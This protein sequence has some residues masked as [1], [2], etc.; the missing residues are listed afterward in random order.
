MDTTQQ[1]RLTK[2]EWDSVEVP[3]SDA[4][5]RIL[6]LIIEGYSNVDIKHNDS[7]SLLNYAKIEKSDMIDVYFYNKF[8]QPIVETLSKPREQRRQELSG[9]Q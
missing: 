9:L 6:N 7:K 3:V 8:F 2:S 4:E 1:K 5:K